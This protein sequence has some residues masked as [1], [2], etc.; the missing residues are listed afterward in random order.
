MRTL[1]LT[2]S[3]GIGSGLTAFCCLGG[4]A[5]TGVLSAF[6]LGFLINDAI[7]IP[8]LVMFLG[9]HLWSIRASSQRHKRKGMF[10]LAAISGIL[11]FS[12]LWISVWVAGV[13]MAGILASSFQNLYFS[14]TAGSQ[15]APVQADGLKE[16]R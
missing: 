1:G 8:V 15:C 11:L 7:L 9:I 16:R 14:R 6:G 4:P 3:S 2:L 10:R 12:G 5:V 13:G